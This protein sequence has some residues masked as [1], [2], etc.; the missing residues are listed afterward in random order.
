MDVDCMLENCLMECRIGCRLH[1][2]IL[3]EKKVY[4]DCRFHDCKLFSQ[5]S[6]MVVAYMVAS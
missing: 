2:C 4:S 1:A 6:S 5:N 3:F